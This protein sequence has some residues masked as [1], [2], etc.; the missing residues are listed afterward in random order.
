M[1]ASVIAIAAL[2]IT[3]TA[4][5]YADTGVEAHLSELEIARI[6]MQHPGHIHRIEQ[7]LRLAEEVPCASK[8]FAELV[9]A[10]TDGRNVRCAGLLL[11]SFPAKRHLSFT[12]DD[13]RYRF[14]LTSKGY[15]ELVPLQAKDAD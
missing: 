12:L 6:E 1:R 14:T 4:V 2:G 3:S 5:A 7:I 15:G 13:H 8:K 10:R 9:Q 11:T